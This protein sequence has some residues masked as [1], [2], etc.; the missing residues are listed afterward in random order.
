MAGVAP[1]TGDLIA[2]LRTSFTVR[3]L[4]LAGVLYVV[5]AIPGAAMGPAGAAIRMRAAGVR[6][7]VRRPE[8]ARP[9]GPWQRAEPRCYP[10]HRP[11]DGHNVHAEVG[12]DIDPGHATSWD[13]VLVLARLHRIA[14]GH[15]G[16]TGRPKLTGRRGIQIW[17]PIARGPTFAETRN[18][19]KQLSRAV[20]AAVPELVSWEWS[21]RDRGGLA[22]LDYTQNVINKTLVAPYSPRAAAGAPVSAPIDWDELDDPV[23]RPGSFT[24]RDFPRRLVLSEATYSGPC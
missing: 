24:I 3:P 17:I 5:F 23:L 16:V 12:A 19:T 2:V 13:D 6:A 4:L 20:G 21:V 18:W 1:V 9:R 11:G 14:L 22:R 8:P 15:L 7:A 10:P